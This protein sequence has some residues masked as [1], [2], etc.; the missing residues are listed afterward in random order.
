MNR[1]QAEDLALV[2]LTCRR[3][4]AYFPITLAS[5]LLADPLT[6]RLR[7]VAVEVDAPNLD[8]VAPLQGHAQVRWRARTDEVSAQVA[9]FSLHRR[10]CHAYWRALGLA[11][12]DARAV[13]LCEDDVIFRDGW[14]G[15]LL[16]CL[17]EMRAVGLEEFH[18]AAYSAYDH[19]HAP[20]RRGCF[21]SSYPAHDFYGTQ[22]M[23]YPAD[24]VAP[25]RDLIWRHGIETHEEPYDLLVKRRAI[26][27][28]HLYATR[29]SIAQ[30]IG[31]CTTGLGGLHTSPSF[32][33]RWPVVGEDGAPRL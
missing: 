24:E 28:Q 3:N 20:L 17:N 33:R 7:E 13:I 31:A 19:D 21:Y 8:C 32:H 12:P 16:E 23:L 14:L 5:A 10:A 4:P 9:A 26:A 30:H 2:F 11:S 6:A 29:H 1:W 25:V 18:I 22:A 27:R 15:M